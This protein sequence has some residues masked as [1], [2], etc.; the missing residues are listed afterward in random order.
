MKA[1][2]VLKVLS[3][4]GFVGFEEAWHWATSALNLVAQTSCQNLLYPPVNFTELEL[5]AAGVRSRCREGSA[6]SRFGGGAPL[7]HHRYGH[8]NS[9]GVSSSETSMAMLLTNTGDDRARGCA[10]N[11]GTRM[12]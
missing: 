11:G 4:S 5:V 10:G 1:E 12:A 2:Q 9:S 6:S 8:S 7:D 3:L